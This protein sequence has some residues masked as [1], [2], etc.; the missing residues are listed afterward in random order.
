MNEETVIRLNGELVGSFLCSGDDNAD[1]ATVKKILTEKGLLNCSTE[2]QKIVRVA[3]AFATAITTLHNKG[4][5]MSIPFVVNGS[6][7]VE[8]FLKAIHVANGS[9]KR[10][11][12]LSD[13]YS[14]LPDSVKGKLDQKFKDNFK[15]SKFN[16]IEDAIRSMNRAFENWRYFHEKKETEVIDS[17]TI[18]HVIFVL[19]DIVESYEK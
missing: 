5:E 15:R 6:F 17:Q 12:K 18:Q 8:L 4:Q 1:S 19:K 7:C 11:H 10:G 9:V 13:L 16:T 3:Q 14:N 2:F